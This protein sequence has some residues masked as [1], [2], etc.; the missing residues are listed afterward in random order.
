MLISILYII[1]TRVKLEVNYF[2]VANYKLNTLTNSWEIKQNIYF[3]M[4][5]WFIAIFFESLLET[6]SSLGHAKYCTR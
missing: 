1:M 4:L 6:L 3:L 2:R 5:V